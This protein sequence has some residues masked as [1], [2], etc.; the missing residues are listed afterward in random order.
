[1]YK[2]LLFLFFV[3]LLSSCSFLSQAEDMLQVSGLHINVHANGSLFINDKAIGTT[4][5]SELKTFLLGLLEEQKDT[6][7]VFLHIDNA[8]PMHKVKNLRNTLQEC[9]ITKISYVM[10]AKETTTDNQ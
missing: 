8:T 3:F 6:L 2:N 1:M 7:M 4:E 10:P 9:G 5:E